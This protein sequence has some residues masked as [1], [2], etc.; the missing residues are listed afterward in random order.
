[1]NELAPEVMDDLER[2][3]KDNFKLSSYEARIYLSLL[4]LGKQNQKQLSQTA[5]VPLPRVYDSVESLMSKGFV[6]KQEDNFSG[7][8]AKQAL[9]GRSSQFEIQFLEEQKRR[10]QAEEELVTVLQKVSQDQT[11]ESNSEISVLKGLDRKSVV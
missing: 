6:V 1:M 4:K 3:L 8:A 9:K 2:S 7:I 11:K 5:Q 10:K